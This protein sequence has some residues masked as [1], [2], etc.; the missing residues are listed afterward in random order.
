M[1]GN[2]ARAR[3]LDRRGDPAAERHFRAALDPANATSIPARRL[4]RLAARSGT[5]RRGDR[6]AAATRPV[7]IRCCFG[8]RWRKQALKRPEAAASIEMLRARFEA[9][10]ARRR[11]SASARQCA[12]RA[13]LCAAT[14]ESALTLALDNWKVQR[15]PA[16]LRI[17]AEAAAATGD[18]A[19]ARH[20]QAMAR[21]D[22]IRVP[23]GGCAG[24]VV[25]RRPNEAHAAA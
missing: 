24:R 15:E 21:R 25:G 7:S 10:H 13:S 5:C 12:V 2:P 9:S 11:H 22:G 23:G 16:D 20:R 17:L 1:A 18:A 19:A 3:S 6:A 8:W 4:Q 14:R